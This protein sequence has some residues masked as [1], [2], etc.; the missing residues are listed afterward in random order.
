MAVFVVLISTGNV[1]GSW[2]LLPAI[3][4]GAATAWRSNGRRLLQIGAELASQ[5]NRSILKSAMPSNTE[6]VSAINIHP[7]DWACPDDKYQRICEEAERQQRRLQDVLEKRHAASGQ[8]D[9]SQRVGYQKVAKDPAIPL[10]LV[11]TMSESSDK[12]KLT[13]RLASGD[14]WEARR[15]QLFYR[16]RPKAGST[17]K[18]IEDASLALDELLTSLG[19]GGA[20]E[21]DLISKLGKSHSE[22]SVHRALRA[23]LSHRLI[24]QEVRL[25]RSFRE[26]CAVFSPRMDARLRSH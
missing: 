23:A 18:P 1:L 2:S 13:L 4:V 6:L 25:G 10:E 9:E 19:S 24:K 21:S 15:L 11:I 26:I 22:A 3:I 12:K 16:H 7:G 17:S 5:S 8:I 14:L 20:S